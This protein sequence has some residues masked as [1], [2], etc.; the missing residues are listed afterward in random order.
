MPTTHLDIE[1]DDRIPIY[2]QIADALKARI[3]S[4]ELEGGGR[5]PSI[6]EL[7]LELR[8][9]PNTVQRAY[10]QLEQGGYIYSQRGMGYFVAADQAMADNAKRETSRAI[11]AEAVKQLLEMGMDGESI[12]DMLREYL[13]EAK[14]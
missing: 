2:L 5:I 4:G 6:R 12:L 11:I 7:S 14:A 1:F 13:K 8:V 9:N 3:L 10:Q